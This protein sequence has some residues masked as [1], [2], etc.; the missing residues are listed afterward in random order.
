MVGVVGATGVAG[1][2]GIGRRRREDGAGLLQQVED[3]L[4]LALELLLTEFPRLV[5]A[6]QFAELNPQRG[7]VVELLLRGV[8]QLAP[9]PTPRPARAPA[10]AASAR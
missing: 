2:T 4:L 1:A 3:A 5:R 8:E 6:V 7:R 10:A 9:P